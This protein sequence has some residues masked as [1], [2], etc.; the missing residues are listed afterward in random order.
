MPAA[1][2]TVESRFTVEWGDCDPAGIVFY[3]RFYAWFDASTWNLF[4]AVGLTYRAMQQDWQALGIP[5]VDAQARF[6]A[7]CRQKEALVCRSTLAEWRERSFVVTHS[8]LNGD[9]EAVVGQEVR[10][11]AVAHPQDAQR[12][13]A[14]PIPPRLRALFQA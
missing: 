3:P 1:S 9:V 12:L 8:I 5:V 11:W 13:Q 4:Q 2:R 14:A 10:I 6:Q 7:P